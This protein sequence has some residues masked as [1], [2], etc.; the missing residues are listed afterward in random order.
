MPSPF[1]KG[2]LSGHKARAPRS[3]DSPL[4]MNAS[5]VAPP[6]EK[7]INRILCLLR[8]KRYHPIYF[9][10]GLGR[11]RAA[12]IAALYGMHYRGMSKQ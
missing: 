5:P 8:D 3:R 6:T 4:D 10:C 7:H 1:R 12:L 2:K 9:H 11:E